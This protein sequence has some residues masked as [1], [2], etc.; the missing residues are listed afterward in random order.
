M[1]R[2]ER[3]KKT[4]ETMDECYLVSLWNDY[5][6]HNKQYSD[7]IYPTS[8]LDEIA[9][10]DLDRPLSEIVTSIQIDFADYSDQDT[11]YNCDIYEHYCSFNH[12]DQRNSP[13]DYGTLAE[14]IYDGNVDVSDYEEFEWMEEEDDE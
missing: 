5:C 1:E 12:L 6:T 13:F 4:L 8:E 14:G 11:Y 9:N 10:Y 3:I 7:Y 2:L